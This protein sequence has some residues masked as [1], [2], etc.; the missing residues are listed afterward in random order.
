MTDNTYSRIEQIANDIDGWGEGWRFLYDPESRGRRA[1]IVRSH[2]LNIDIE[3][4]MHMENTESLVFA[5]CQVCGSDGQWQAV[6]VS[7]RN[8]TN[9]KALDYINEQLDLHCESPQ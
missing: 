1:R 6:S 8:P 4:E 3:I 9:R 7:V 2:S 5:G